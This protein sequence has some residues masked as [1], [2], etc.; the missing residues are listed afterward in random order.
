MLSHR[1]GEAH[2]KSPSSILRR[3]VVGTLLFGALPSQA[4]SSACALLK[5]ADLNSFLGGIG[6]AKPS[7]GACTWT[8]AGSPRKL[9]A[10]RMQAAGPAAEMAYAGAR[11]NA[12]DEGKNKVTDEPGIGD[13]AFSVQTSFGVALFTLKQGRMLQIQYWTGAPGTAKDVEA[14]RPVASKAAAAF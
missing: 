4:D 13:R 10:A 12:P 8:A 2:M 11:K 9:M 3:L 7:G 14:L 5:Q 6:V 1:L